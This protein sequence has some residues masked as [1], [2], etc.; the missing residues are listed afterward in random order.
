MYNHPARLGTIVLGNL[1]A[2]EHHFR[3][4]AMVDCGNAGEVGEKR[5]TFGTRALFAT[6]ENSIP[7]NEIAMEKCRDKTVKGMGVGVGT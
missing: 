3:Q 4:L 7:I 6:D 1:A 2:L 5:Q